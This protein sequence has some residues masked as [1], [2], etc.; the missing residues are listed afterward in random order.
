MKEIREVQEDC[1]ELEASIESENEQ[2]AK[3]RVLA[4]FTKHLQP[5]NYTRKDE[6]ALNRDSGQNRQDETKE[7]DVV[8]SDYV[9]RK[10]KVL[11]VLY[12]A[13][14]AL[15]SE[16]KDKIFNICNFLTERITVG[17]GE[18][19]GYQ[20]WKW[21]L[22]DLEEQVAKCT[23]IS[24]IVNEVQQMSG[25]NS[26]QRGSGWWDTMG[27]VDEDWT[28]SFQG[29]LTA[30][31]RLVG[32]LVGR[33]IPESIRS[34]LSHSP[35]I[36]EAFGSLSQIR[37]AVDTALEQLADI[38]MQRASLL[39]LERTYYANVEEI[40]ER[41]VSLEMAIEKG[42]DHLSW[43]EAEE[44]ASQVEACR[45]QL[46]KL[47]NAWDRR[48]A[49][50][51]TLV[52]KEASAR[53]ALVA[54]EQRF[55]SLITVERD[56]D[57]HP[58]RG[59]VLLATFARP[60]SELES[61]DRKLPLFG[62]ESSLR[63]SSVDQTE[64]VNSGFSG[65]ESVWRVTN[66]LKD[67]TFFVWKVGIID[68]CLDSCIRNVAPAVDHT[69]GFDQSISSQKRKLEILV[70]YSLDQY[71]KERLDPVLLECL[72]KEGDSLKHVLVEHRELESNLAK[73]ELDAVKRAQGLLVE[74][75]N[76]HETA[77]AAKSAASAM[78]MQV[79]ELT[80]DLQKANLEAAQLEWLHDYILCHLEQNTIHEQTCANEDNFPSS[81]IKLN[82]RNLLENL[83][84]AMS[85]IT[86]A[87][88]GLQN[89][90]RSAISTEEQLER[91]MGWACAGPNTGG[92]SNYS[93]RGMGIPPEFHEHLRHRRQLLWAVQEQAAGI[94][95]LCAAAL[96]FEDSRD[97]FL[98]SP[99]VSTGG[100][101]SEG[102]AWQQA[103]MNIISRL[104]ISYHSFT[105][106]DH[107]WHLAQKNM[108]AAGASLSTA[109]NE[110]CLVSMK[111]KS[112]S[113]ELQATLSNMRDLTVKANTDLSAFCRVARG[114]SALTT[115]SGSML[116]EVLAI[117]EGA[118]G[119][120][121]VYRLAKEAAAQHSNL[122]SEL[123]KV[124]MLLL[125]LESMLAS[126][127]NAVIG[128]I[129][130]EGEQKMEISVGQGQALIQSLNLKLGE[131][132]PVLTTTVPVLLN[133]VKELHIAL[134]RLAR[135][136]SFD[137]GVLHKAL[138]G[139]GESQEA[140]SQELDL[141][142]TELEADEVLSADQS[143]NILEAVVDNDENNAESVTDEELLLQ[144]D[145][146]SWI[147]PPDSL[148][149]NDSESNL[150]SSDSHH[151]DDSL[152]ISNDWESH[153]TGTDKAKFNEG[154]VTDASGFTMN[155]DTACTS[156]SFFA[157]SQEDPLLVGNIQTHMKFE[158]TEDSDNGIISTGNS[159]IHSAKDT[160][161]RPEGSQ[162]SI[163]SNKVSSDSQNASHL[164]LSDIGLGSLNAS[165]RHQTGEIRMRIKEKEPHTSR[166]KGRVESYNELCTLFSSMN[167]EQRS[168]GIRG[169]N[170]YAVSVLKRV[171]AKLDGRDIDGK[172]QFTVPE[173]VDHLLRQATSIDNL[174]NM[175][176]GWTPWI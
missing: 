135:T 149:T 26:F 76:A 173:Q 108:E 19:I 164:N 29:C 168:H 82:R 147:S 77:R 161:Q 58:T 84:S 117:T 155:E 66:I 115:E 162:A 174:C 121:D 22:P 54:A 85:A 128:L 18:D 40:T 152:A 114:N 43:E 133:T 153:I 36:M 140:R 126:A 79:G 170:A 81:F 35:A 23:L 142:R 93:G 95:K 163:S 111:S 94:V 167:T 47:N 20:N 44:L 136:A 53:G 90:E 80:Q 88:E 56:G 27:S 65:F 67:H 15:Y 100:A 116:E 70:E 141:V 165:E 10:V 92:G 98:R 24:G 107:E 156:P 129:N 138:E 166:A 169:K 78:K 89:C 102:R 103:Y 172:R 125:P 118:E 101:L 16:I 60:F 175:Y 50:S 33:A 120:H 31:R 13:A 5:S 151:H 73:K 105:R 34:V 122:M 57:M 123:N 143:S 38:E 11:T 160:N 130:R 28:L 157:H 150:T 39:E 127:S 144:G 83:R 96:D 12:L 109:T 21:C 110:L 2:K 37:G 3:D 154:V 139:V 132:C 52:R 71:L 134:T 119:A 113:G 48:D 51:S 106:A 68:A 14:A 91:A 49:Q 59:K 158:G 176:E 137:A 145:E 6:D 112:T 146:D 30:I 124:N 25:Q 171:E 8:S 74:Y 46:D 41:K 64:I 148:Y 32:H 45:A 131:V 4:I 97:G 75:S 63:K 99:D 42:R 159:Q 55:E 9:E 17:P 62:Y 87:T 72:E 69:L 1:S 86:R 7:H 104:D 61:Y